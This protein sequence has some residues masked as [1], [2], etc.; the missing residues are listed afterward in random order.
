V[1]VKP[2]PVYPTLQ[3]QAKL[4]GVFVQTAFAEHPPLFVEHSFTSIF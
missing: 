1:H 3:S 2:S 4:P